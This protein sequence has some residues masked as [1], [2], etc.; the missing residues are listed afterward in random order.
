MSNSPD[1]SANSF[2]NYKLKLH[3]FTPSKRSLWTIVG[4]NDEYWLDP[5]LNYCTCKHYYFKTLSG[6]DKCQHLKILNELIKNKKYDQTDY[7]DEE[8]YDFLALLIKD[9]L[10]K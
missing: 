10:P 9:I 4:K 8:Y 6:K 5:E 7:S 2:T 1:I 3:S